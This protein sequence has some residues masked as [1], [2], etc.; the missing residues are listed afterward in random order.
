[1]PIAARQ[2]PWLLGLLSVLR[3]IVWKLGVGPSGPLGSDPALWGLTAL[4]LEAG[5]APLTVPLYPWLIQALPGGLINTGLSLSLL[6]AA[7]L[8]LAGWW[9]AKPYGDRIALTNLE[10]GLGTEE[11]N[12]GRL[13]GANIEDAPR[14]LL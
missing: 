5:N 10:V 11:S 3:L 12:H 9:A 7:L 2:V 1:M 8:P 4:D 14:L 6:S 13:V